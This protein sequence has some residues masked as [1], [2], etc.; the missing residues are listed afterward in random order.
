MRSFV[1]DKFVNPRSSYEDL[2]SF[3]G[4]TRIY[5]LELALG[6]YVVPCEMTDQQE[7]TKTQLFGSIILK[8]ENVFCRILKLAM[9][10]R[11]PHCKS[12]SV[13]FKPCRL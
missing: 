11:V 8:F 2:T 3:K 13:W 4:K 5:I 6:S 9:A 10:I 1:Q 12:S 7:D